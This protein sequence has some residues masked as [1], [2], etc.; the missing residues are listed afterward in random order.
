MF[1]V[2][3]IRKLT[4][5]VS[6]SGIAASETAN[7]AATGGA[8][9][10]LLALDVPGGNAAAVMATALAIKGVNMGPLLSYKSACLYVHCFCCTGC[11]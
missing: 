4:V 10:P 6:R 7:N 3:N 9:V 2:P 11:C 1:G 5:K 8:M